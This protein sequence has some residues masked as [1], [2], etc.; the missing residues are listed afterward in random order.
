MSRLRMCRRRT[1]LLVCGRGDVGWRLASVS[2]PSTGEFLDPGCLQWSS[3]QV[4]RWGQEI[5]WSL[6]AQAEA[7]AELGLSR[8]EMCGSVEGV[9]LRTCGLLGMRG[10]GGVGVLGGDGRGQARVAR[11]LLSLFLAWTPSDSASRSQFTVSKW[12]F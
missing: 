7:E 12:N 4:A 10:R 5:E 11:T 3:R 8:W 2:L 1:T 9:G 6:R